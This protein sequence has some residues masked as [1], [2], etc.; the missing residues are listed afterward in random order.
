MILFA[1]WVERLWEVWEWVWAR[2]LP[3][4]DD[5]LARIEEMA[6]QMLGEQR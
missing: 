3:D 1:Q 4:A 5:T 2:W 6:G